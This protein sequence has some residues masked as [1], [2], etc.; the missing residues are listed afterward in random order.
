MTSISLQPLDQN[1]CL[2]PH[3][4]YDVHDLAEIEGGL[5]KLVVLCGRQIL[6]LYEFENYIFWNNSVIGIDIVY[7]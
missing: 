1:Q 7:M 2:V 5:P 3:V 4:L 6:R